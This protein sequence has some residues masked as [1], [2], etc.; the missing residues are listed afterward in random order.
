MTLLY[1]ATFMFRNTSLAVMSISTRIQFLPPKGFAIQ[2]TDPLRNIT[3]TSSVP[4]KYG[5]ELLADNSQLQVN[6]LINVKSLL[7]LQPDLFRVIINLSA[8]FSLQNQSFFTFSEFLLEFKG[9]HAI[10][11]GIYFALSQPKEP[12]VNVEQKFSA[13]GHNTIMYIGLSL[14]EVRLYGMSP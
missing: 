11:E 9:T 13:V 2:Q 8:R 14:G 3:L 5:L 4:W 7:I 10:R 1:Y 6:S 12:P